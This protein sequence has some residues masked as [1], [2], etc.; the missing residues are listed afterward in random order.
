MP[1]QRA[2]TNHR[3]CQLLRNACWQSAGAHARVRAVGYAHRAAT[4]QQ[5]LREITNTWTFSPLRSWTHDFASITLQARPSARCAP[6]LTASLQSFSRPDRQPEKKKKKKKSKTTQKNT[7]DMLEVARLRPPSWYARGEKKKK[8]KKKKKKFQNHSKKY[9]RYVGGRQTPPT[10]MVRPGEKKKKKK[11]KKKIPKPLQK[12]RPIRWRSPDS[13]HLHGTPG[14]EKKKKK[15]KKKKK[16]QNHS[17][18]YG[19]YVGGRQTPPTHPQGPPAHPEP[20][21]K[22]KKKNTSQPLRVRALISK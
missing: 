16:I 9:G 5:K 2:R 21:K 22:G 15:K 14:G 11:K 6:G 17:K 12:I 18:K 7:A 19:R 13:A 1:L 10:F 8:K 4:C 20:K 3:A